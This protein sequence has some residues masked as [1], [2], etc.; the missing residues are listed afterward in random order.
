[1][2]G[3]FLSQ[4]KKMRGHAAN[5]LE[6]AEKVYHYRRDVLEPAVLGELQSSTAK[7]RAVLKERGDAARLKL[8]IEPLEEVLRRAGGKIYPKSSL[9]ENV[10]FFLIAAIVILGIRTFFLQPFKIPTNSMW[11]S[12]YGMTP[13]VFRQ[14]SEEPSKV[15]SA[16]RLLAFGA[17]TRRIDA[18]AA[19]DV[20]IPVGN[21]EGRNGEIHF[22]VVPG[23]KW[24]V[25]P[26]QLREYTLYVNREPVTFQVPL[27]FDFDWVIREAFFPEAP[28]LSAGLAGLVRAGETERRVV[29]EGN[30]GYELPFARVTKGVK[31][32]QRILSFDI[33]TGDQLIVDRFSYHF[34]RPSVGSGFVF[35][36]GN[37]PMLREKQGDQ[38]Y[39]KRL[40]GTP[41]DK[42]EIRPDPEAKANTRRGVPT[43][44]LYRNGQPIEGAEAF[45]LNNS[46]EP[47]YRGYVPYGLLVIGETLSVPSHSYLALGDNSANSYDGRSWGFVPGDDVVGRPL[48]IYYPFSKRWG[49]AR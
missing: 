21:I 38:Y 2:F 3:P 40:V 33:M 37:I 42:I 11:P 14:P 7:L 29:Y 1:M 20:W 43:G 35:R 16:F 13:D 31:A 32:G 25:I 48:M 17:T 24:L 46:K 4:D 6:L 30:R 36:T 39:I 9:V 8:A 27:D 34:V 12:Y 26:T 45:V 19:G 22:R 10:E 15:E 23:R 28:S 18:P 49:P 44:I 41:G 47:P 5:W